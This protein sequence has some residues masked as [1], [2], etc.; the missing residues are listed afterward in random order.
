MQQMAKDNDSSAK[1]VKATENN[2]S[3]S[4]EKANVVKVFES[5][6]CTYKSSSENGIKIHK[7]DLYRLS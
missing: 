6:F 1:Q 7:T 5:D 3:N 4:S 2:D